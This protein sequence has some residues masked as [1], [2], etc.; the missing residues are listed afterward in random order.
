MVGSLGE[1]SL[2]EKCS[3]QKKTLINVDFAEYE[4]LNAA[5]GAAVVVC[6]NG[7]AKCRPLPPNN[8]YNKSLTQKPELGPV[9]GRCSRTGNVKACSLMLCCVEFAVLED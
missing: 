5:G 1:V 3:K 7:S 6:V 2:S 9:G 8:F 4:T